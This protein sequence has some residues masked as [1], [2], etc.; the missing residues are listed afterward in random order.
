MG[1]WPVVCR[2][3]LCKGRNRKKKR[4]FLRIDGRTGDVCGTFSSLM[5]GRN[6]ELRNNKRGR[7]AGRERGDS[8]EKNRR[9][10]ERARFTDRG[11]S[12][13]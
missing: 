9:E 2:R 11:R 1:G 10:E 8:A 12:R 13:D 7:M 4:N 5:T 3:V 6:E